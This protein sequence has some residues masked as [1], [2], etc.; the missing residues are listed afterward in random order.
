M[1]RKEEILD[2]VIEIFQ[3]RGIQANFTISELARNV[4]I[5]KSTIYEYFTTKEEIITEAIFKVIESSIALITNRSLSAEDMF[6]QAFKK[7]VKHV[8]QIAKSSS[9]V[10]EFMTPDFKG[11]LKE[12]F[13]G[14]FAN[15]MK[16]I[17]L[18]YQNLFIEIIGKGVQE[19][20]LQND[21]LPLKGMIFASLLTGSITRIGN[22]NIEE[23]K[24]MDL[25]EYVNEMYLT[26][27]KIFN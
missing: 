23:T 4:D 1:S 15:R 5:G 13:D 10:F 9:Y 3:N 11:N 17:A 22:F 2:A 25:D 27:I 6:E 19:G 7:E 16:D 26:T 8:L 24:T 18:D 12:K 20:I 14:E 21:Q